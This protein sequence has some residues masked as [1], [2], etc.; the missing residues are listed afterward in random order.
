MDRDYRSLTPCT[1]HVSLLQ[2][3]KHGCRSDAYLTDKEE[4]SFT[5][6]IDDDL[7]SSEQKGSLLGP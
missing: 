4:G 7:L 3:E 2:P 5:V 6:H 1:E